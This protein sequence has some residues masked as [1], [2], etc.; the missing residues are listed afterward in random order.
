MPLQIMNAGH[1]NSYKK[2][3][4][5]ISLEISQSQELTRE[6][7]S[8]ILE[9]AEEVI[10]KYYQNVMSTTCNVSEENCSILN[11]GFAFKD[12]ES[13]KVSKKANDELMRLTK[14]DAIV[15]EKVRVFS[16]PNCE[17]S[18][19]TPTSMDILERYITGNLSENGDTL[20]SVWRRSVRPTPMGRSARGYSKFYMIACMASD[21]AWANLSKKVFKRRIVEF[22]YM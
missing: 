22:L 18:S 19:D 10:K 9:R 8:H 13:R 2:N 15:F 3:A 11:I 20:V 21:I 4:F 1:I 5:L 12:Q 6:D 16:I 7:K 17:R 14:N